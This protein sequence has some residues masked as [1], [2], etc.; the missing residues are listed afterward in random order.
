MSLGKY[1][2]TIQLC[3]ERPPKWI[4][5]SKK[6]AIHLTSAAGLRTLEVVKLEKRSL[7]KVCV[8][9]QLYIP[10]TGERD[11]VY[12]TQEQLR[13][14]NCEKPHADPDSVVL[15]KL[16]ALHDKPDRISHHALPKCLT[17]SAQTGL[18]QPVLQLSQFH[19]LF[20]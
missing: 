20:N 1:V 14:I 19:A 13:G 15:S 9:I 6:I 12:E 2:E 11:P 5:S 17:R 3:I 18:A 7:N 4:P 10:L 8:A 16:S